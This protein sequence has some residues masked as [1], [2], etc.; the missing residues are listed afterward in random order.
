MRDCLF[1]KGLVLAIII[2]FIGLS[3]FPS[4]ANPVE[5]IYMPTSKGNTLYVGG[6]GPDNYTKIQDAIED[7]SDGD[8]VFV[9][10]DSSPYNE[11]VWINKSINL[12]GENKNTTVI[13]GWGTGYRVVIY[14]TVDNVVVSGLRIYNCSELLEKG[15]LI[16]SSAETSNIVIKGNIIE[17]NW[18]G[19]G[20]TRSSN[21][22]IL[23]N[24][25]INT[26][27]GILTALASTTIKGNTILNHTFGIAMQDTSNIVEDNYIYTPQTSWTPD[28][29]KNTWGVQDRIIYYPSCM[30]IIKGNTIINHLWGISCGNTLN[31]IISGNTL[32]DNYLSI[33]LSNSSNNE[34]IGNNITNNYWWGLRIVDK[35][36]NNRIIRNTIANNSEYGIYLEDS[37]YNK[38]KENNIMKSNISVYFENSLLNRWMRNYWERPR[39][40]P[41]LIFGDMRLGKITIPWFNIDWNPA[42]EPYDI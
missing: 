40:L 38:F 20:E 16:P 34:I 23:N 10:D 21:N 22:S 32:I 29:Q 28:E 1:K 4:T 15:I 6:I 18:I 42:S 37:F 41:Y 24:I 17:N 8:T 31:H 2:L 11:F 9:Y 19:I 36:N 27:F 26:T 33:S 3:V 39:L 7:A 5:K 35:S 13:D 25:I 14:I 30:S 12:I